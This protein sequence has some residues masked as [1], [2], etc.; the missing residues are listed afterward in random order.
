MITTEELEKR[1]DILATTLHSSEE[2]L[3]SIKERS[4]II[5]QEIANIRGAI[6]EL[7]NL[8]DGERRAF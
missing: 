6:L 2:T 7:D 4:K 1:R 3:A 5:K 8:I